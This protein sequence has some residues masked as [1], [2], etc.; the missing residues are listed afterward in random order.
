MSARR[1]FEQY[2]KEDAKAQRERHVAPD[3][4]LEKVMRAWERFFMVSGS[5]MVKGAWNDENVDMFK[6]MALGFTENIV[7]S[8]RTINRFL[9]M[10]LAE[11]L[12]EDV[13]DELGL[14]TSAL[15][16]TS[17][18]KKIDLRLTDTGILLPDLSIWSD[19]EVI[20][21]GK[22]GRSTGWRMSAGKMTING[23]V[24]EGLGNGMRGGTIIVNGDVLIQKVDGIGFEGERIAP[25]MVGGEIFINGNVIIDPDW[26]ELSE[27]LMPEKEGLVHLKGRIIKKVL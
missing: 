2:K 16:N 13:L 10:L 9:V 23:D 20:V 26:F 25:K 15:V 19:R 24:L 3:R 22:L 7:A 6:E 8:P 11:N 4:Q 21:A 1:R 27:K 5:E 17:Q 14:F 18:R 12:G